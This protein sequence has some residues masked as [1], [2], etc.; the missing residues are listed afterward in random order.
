MR[1]QIADSILT[2]DEKIQG[3]MREA[4]DYINTQLSPF[5]VTP[6]QNPDDEL[7]MLGSSLAAA[8]YNY[9]QSPQGVMDAIK[10][11]K[12]AIQGHVKANFFKATE[13]GLS[14]NT[15]AK[16]NSAISGNET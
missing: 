15:I 11:W 6:I 12:K 10:D 16:T 7:K 5:T 3:F 8:F 9:W 14:D 13:D 1:L 2:A 4:D